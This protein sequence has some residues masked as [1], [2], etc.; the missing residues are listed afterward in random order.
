MSE[1][2]ETINKQFDEEILKYKENPID[3]CDHKTALKL[4][5]EYW[6]DSV[7]FPTK[8][9][10]NS[11]GRYFP[12]V[13]EGTMFLGEEQFAHSDALI[14]AKERVASLSYKDVARAFIYGVARGIT[15]YR[16]AL[17]AYLHIKKIP[18]HED[19]YLCED[20]YWSA[21]KSV[22]TVCGIICIENEGEKFDKHRLAIVIV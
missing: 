12:A 8:F 14:I 3:A 21:A 22:D 7:E 5:R 4:L 17:P 10:P 18:E 20:K 2:S 11:V 9:W 6:N 1:N 15:A 19:E 16:T 13:V